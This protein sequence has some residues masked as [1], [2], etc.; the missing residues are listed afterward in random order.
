MPTNV[1]VYQ[2]NYL[3]E[4]LAQATKVLPA[5]AEISVVIPVYRSRDSLLLLLEG[6]ERELSAIGRRYELVL[7]DDCS[8]DDTWTVLKE[9]KEVRPWLKI[10]HLLR[11][12]G[13]HN[14]LLCG[15][16]IAEGKIVVTM[17]DDLQNPPEEIHKLIAAIDKGYDLAIAAYAAQKRHALKD[18]GGRLIDTVQRRIFRLPPTFQLTSFRAV[19]RIIID[20]VVQMSGTYP[21]VTSML[22]S[23]TSKYVNV[24]VRH[25]ERRFG[26]S[27]YTLKRSFLL[28]LNLLLTYSS[29]PLYLVAALCFVAFA[30]SASF[31]LWTLWQA[32]FHGA[33]VQGWASTIVIVSLLNALILLALVIQGL[34]LSRLNQQVSRARVS[35][36]IGELHE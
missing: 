9:L 10:A 33:S 5:T 14:A 23:H 32:V 30:F 6:L 15:F 35:F 19:R 31:G 4:P 22:L 16:T 28:A 34:Y 12:S 3:V 1:P 8:P 17:D 7:V 20:N 25:D 36:T 2:N 29:Y 21:Y 11:N 18:L 13:Q 26:R 27:N 24:P